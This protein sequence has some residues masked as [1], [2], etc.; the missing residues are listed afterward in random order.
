MAVTK[1]LARLGRNYL[2][3]EPRRKLRRGLFSD[4]FLSCIPSPS[5]GMHIDF[6]FSVLDREGLPVPA[7]IHFRQAELPET[8]ERLRGTRGA[9]THERRRRH[10][11]AGADRTQH[12]PDRTHRPEFGRSIRAFVLS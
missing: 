8:H 11:P 1:K 2:M 10:R 4:C 5:G 7:G 9:G 6:K 12:A 3:I